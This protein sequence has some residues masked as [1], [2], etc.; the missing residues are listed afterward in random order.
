MKKTLPKFVKLCENQQLIT[1]SITDQVNTDKETGQKVLTEVFDMCKVYAKM[2]PKD[3]TDEQKQRRVE[4]C[5]DLLE[6][7]DDVLSRI[8]TGDET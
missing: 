2:V 6:W 4:L 8:I 5:T 7:Q 3:L 1:K